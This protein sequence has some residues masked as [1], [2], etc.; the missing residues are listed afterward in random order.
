MIKDIY[1]K[2]RV[3]YPDL[4]EFEKENK[5]NKIEALQYLFKEASL[6]DKTKEG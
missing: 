5:T 2:L 3:G 6:R 1:D 4:F